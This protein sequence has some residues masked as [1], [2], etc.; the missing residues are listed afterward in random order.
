MARYL[1]T[2][3]RQIGYPT[4]VHVANTIDFFDTVYPAKGVGVQVSLAGGWIADYPSPIDFFDT[5]LRCGV[6]PAD[7]FCDPHLDSL[8]RD[9]EAAQATDPTRAV[10]LWQRADREAV[11]Q[12]PWVP[13]TNTLGL[14]VVSARVGNYQHN[15]HWGILLDQLWVH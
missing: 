9:A 15:P 2:V 3:L 10:Q 12:A 11:D 7:R 1:A 6:N 13:L 4:S 14:D 8:V 5:F